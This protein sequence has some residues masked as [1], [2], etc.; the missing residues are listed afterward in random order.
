[1]RPDHALPSGV[2]GAAGQNETGRR[3]PAWTWICGASSVALLLTFITMAAHVRLG[4]GHWPTPMTEDYRTLGFRIHEWA[5]IGILMFTVYVAGP[6][7]LVFLF[8]R[9]LRLSWRAHLAQL[10]AYGAGWLLIFLA[11][12]YDPTTFTDWFLD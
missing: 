4:L 7:W 12:K 5:L 11:G 1:M 10:L 3:H 8:F 9:R 6:L 2:A